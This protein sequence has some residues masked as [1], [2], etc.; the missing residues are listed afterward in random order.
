MPDSVLGHLRRACNTQKCIHV[1]GKHNDLDDVGMG[2]LG[3]ESRHG[4]LGHGLGRGPN[5]FTFLPFLAH[6]RGPI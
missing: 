4:H 3:A 1:S 2:T 6:D 5:F